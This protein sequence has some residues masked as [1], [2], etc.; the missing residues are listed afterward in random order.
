MNQPSRISRPLSGLTLGISISESED[1]EIRGFT[2][3]DV[4]LVTVALCRRLI[5]L[6]AAVNL[7]HQ[8]RPG[9][10]MEA[11]VQFARTYQED[12]SG[13]IINNYLVFPERAGLSDED[14]RQLSRVVRIHEGA[15]MRPS[16]GNESRS[17]ALTEMRRQLAERSSG[18][19]ALSGRF[20]ASKVA[21][22][23]DFVPGLV[24]ETALMLTQPRP[25]PVYLS[26]M[27]GGVAS[28]LINTLESG[29][30]NDRFPEIR[31]FRLASY[32][33]QIADFG[34]RRLADLCGL[35]S[36][37]LQELFAAQNLD[38]I[39]RLTASGIHGT[40]SA[41]GPGALVE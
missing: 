2:R 34:L 30:T 11:V 15:E 24:E 41:F 31:S 25:K 23:A 9:G 6:G 8:W 18:S 16:D 12:L 20:R 26:H 14:R 28:L 22:S 36:L 39:L 1:L 4:N 3:G 38:T 29:R 7:G 13:P 27:M 21:Q 10:I 35:T 33:G 17:A 32:L 5:A 40:A 37:Q 19:I